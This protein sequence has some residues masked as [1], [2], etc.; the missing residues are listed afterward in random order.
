MAAFAWSAHTTLP[1]EQECVV[2]ASRLPLRRYRHVPAFLRHTLAIRRQLRGT[3]GL[4]GFALDAELLRKTFWTVSAWTD[5]AALAAFNH[6]DPHHSRVI[7]IR[8]AMD[9]TTFVTWTSTGADLPIGW[10][11]VHRRISQANIERH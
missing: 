11:E 6:A 9:A 8:P 7:K 1:A 3:D 2:M 10:D 5:R 4:V